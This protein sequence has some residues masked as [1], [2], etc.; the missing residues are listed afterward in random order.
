ME[1]FGLNSRITDIQSALG[2]SQLRKLNLFVNR[3]KKIAKLYD[4]HFKELNNLK[5]QYINRNNK[6]SYH[7]Y[8][9]LIDFKK[10][11]KTKEELF[12]YF[13]KK[14]I[15]LQVHYK[16]TYKFKYYKKVKFIKSKSMKNSEKFYDQEVSLP[17]YYELTKKKQ[18][19]VINMMKK[20]LKN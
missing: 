11:K 14:G 9:V 18:I 16:P 4:N 8:P 12:K 19:R 17:I 1:F 13:K 20:F 6:S 5:R 3:R 15:N 7:L 2:I 10:T